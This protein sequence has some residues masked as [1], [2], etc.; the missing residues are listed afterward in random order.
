MK[1]GNAQEKPAKQKGGSWECSI[2]VSHRPGDGE[3]MSMDDTSM[4]ITGK[5][6]SPA[7]AYADAC[8]RAGGMVKAM[9]GGGGEMRPK[10][11]SEAQFFEGEKDGD[12]D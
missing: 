8:D 11:R 1:M 12:D 7:A 9:G 2:R 10:V 6:S 4:S 3:T 5:G